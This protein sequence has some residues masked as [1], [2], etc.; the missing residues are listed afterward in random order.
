MPKEKIVLK[1]TKKAKENKKT[2]KKSVYKNLL[3]KSEEA[4]NKKE[5]KLINNTISIEKS[6]KLMK[7]IN[8]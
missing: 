4:I 3:P 1:N 7:Y 8:Y 5:R 6:E 2:K